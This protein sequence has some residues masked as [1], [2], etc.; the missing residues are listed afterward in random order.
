MRQLFMAVALSLG[1]AACGSL[2]GAAVGSNSMYGR[3]YGNGSDASVPSDC[4]GYDQRQECVTAQLP[5]T[6]DPTAP[7]VLRGPYGE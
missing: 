2:G 6:T 4:N 7:Y 1:V 3:T 5:G